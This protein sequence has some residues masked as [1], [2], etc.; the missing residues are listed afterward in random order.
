MKALDTSKVFV[1]KYHYI[2]DNKVGYFK[3]ILAIYA[4]SF[5]Q[6]GHLHGLYKGL[7]TPEPGPADLSCVV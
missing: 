2:P 3:K 4:S 5:D 7:L 1:P 6:V